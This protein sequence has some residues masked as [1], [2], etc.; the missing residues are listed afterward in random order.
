MAV[1]KNCIAV[2]E[3]VFIGFHANPTDVVREI[4]SLVDVYDDVL[5]QWKIENVVIMGDFNAACSYVKDKDWKNIRLATDKRFW[6][7]IDD[8][9]DTT[10]QGTRCAYDRYVKYQVCL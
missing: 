5:K 1:S 7:L 10:V 6:W 3:M 2:S 4:D 9:Q 8:C